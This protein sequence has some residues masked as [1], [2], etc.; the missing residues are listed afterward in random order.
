MKIRILLAVVVLATIA[1]PL[2]WMQA[3]KTIRS[4]PRPPDSGFAFVEGCN[5]IFVAAVTPDLRWAIVVAIDVFDYGLQ[6]NKLTVSLAESNGDSGV[7]LMESS[8]TFENAGD[9]FCSDA[10]IPRC[11]RIW[12]ADLGTVDITIPNL[13]A[14]RWSHAMYDAN[15]VLSGVRFRLQKSLF[16]V[17]TS[18]KYLEIRAE[19]LGWSPG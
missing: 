2:A 6:T 12:K 15:V 18:I 14:K 10:S 9:L 19:K 3:T 11:I 7:Y 4:I 5:D 13:P 1:G 16:P 8:S 17:H